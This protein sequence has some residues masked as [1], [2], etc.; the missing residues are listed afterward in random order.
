M[1]QHTQQRIV[2]YKN[3]FI[4]TGKPKNLCDSL[5]CDNP[6]YCRGLGPNPQCL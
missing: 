2:S 6:F 1:T 4:C 5:Y 3:S